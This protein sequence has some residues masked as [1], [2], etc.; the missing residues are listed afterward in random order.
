MTIDSPPTAPPKL[1]GTTTRKVRVALA[2]AAALLIGALLAPR[3]VP[4]PLLVSEERAAPLLEAEV[5]RREPA[6]LFAGIQQIARDVV[7]YGVALAPVEARRPGTMADVVDGPRPPSMPAGFGVRV[8]AAGDVLTHVAALNGRRALDLAHGDGTAAEARLIAYEPET[9]LA[10]L[11]IESPLGLPPA[12]P[13]AAEAPSVGSLAVA[14]GRWDGRDLVTPVLVSTP[15]DGAYAISAFGPAIAPGTPLYNFNGELFAIAGRQAGLAFPAAGAFERLEARAAA[16]RGY[17]ASVGIRFQPLEV[18]L[19]SV[20]ADRG[21]LVADLIEAGPAAAAGIEPGDVLVA[22]GEMEVGS[23]E[24]ARA[25]VSALQPGVNA[26]F[27]V[28]RGG[29]PQAV[30]VMVGSAFDI[31]AQVRPRE[32]APVLPRARDLFPE[33]LLLAARVPPEA[34]VI[35]VNGRTMPTRAAV[36]REGRRAR[37]AMLLYL[38]H[39]GERYFASVEGQP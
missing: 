31:P 27:H 18:G 19:A 22:I 15:G 35:T 21:V 37:G 32:D 30:T 25:A 16:G 13:L 2:S 17:P 11:R 3:A 39:E 10:L 24:E 28:L 7:I 34:R 1:L 23:P 20:F 38:E 12:A 9:G 8:T 29:P 5:Q 36:E 26:T 6:R 14:V 4:P 33:P